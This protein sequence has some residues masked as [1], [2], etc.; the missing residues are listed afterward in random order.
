MSYKNPTGL[1]TGSSLST[2]IS[3]QFGKGPNREEAQKKA[4]TTA[5]IASLAQ[6][7][8]SS[9]TPKKVALKDFTATQKNK[10]QNLYNDIA[11]YDLGYKDFDK[12]SDTFFHNLID[13]YS[14]IQGHL[15]NGTLVDEQLG[16]KDLA[17]INNLVN[18]YGDAIP[19][20]LKISQ[21]IERASKDPN[22]PQLSIT[23]PPVDQMQI[24][25]KI[26]NGEKVDIIQE[27]DSI[28]LKDPET[29]TILNVAEFNKAFSNNTNP[30]LKYEADVSKPLDTAFTSYMKDKENNFT[31]AFTTPEKITDRN[32]KEVE[33][34]TMTIPQQV[35]LKKAMIGVDNEST[36]VPDG[37]FTALI[38]EQ[39]ESIWE[40]IMDGGR[41][42][43]VFKDDDGSALEWYAGKNGVPVPGDKEFPLYQKQYETMLAYLSNKSLQD[44]AA[45]EGIKLITEN[46][47]PKPK[48]DNENEGQSDG[49]GPRAMNQPKTQAEFNKQWNSLKPGEKLTG[50]NGIEYEKK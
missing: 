16:R 4:R 12:Q 28:I 22:S 20:M 23:G 9:I 6:G 13:K 36:G 45:S 17:K 26:T 35:S 8:L 5:N 21:A 24:I 49:S 47:D 39:G 37:Q 50:P 31:S 30:Y 34:T 27:G 15:N 48:D 40:D 7:V 29:G 2:I 38:N 25:T 19:R 11:S 44:N 43:D 14:E 32:G 42:Y 10:Q 18:V 46:K 3:Q 41:G 1:S 33:I